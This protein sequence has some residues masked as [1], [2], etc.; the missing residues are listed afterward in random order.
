MTPLAT[1]QQDIY[2]HDQAGV[3]TLS[4]Q[5]QCAVHC[6][7][8]QQTHPQAH[9]SM[10]LSFDNSKPLSF[11]P[12]TDRCSKN[13]HLKLEYALRAK[14]PSSKLIYS[15]HSQTSTSFKS[16]EGFVK[17]IEFLEVLFS[18]MDTSSSISEKDY[19]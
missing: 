2:G 19:F 11:N 7:F 16:P 3:P 1:N 9:S 18:G 12:V 14:A 17:V 15:S 4:C 13:F 8:A 5:A 6:G 10:E